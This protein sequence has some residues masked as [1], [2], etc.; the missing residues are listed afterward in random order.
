MQHGQM[1][2]SSAQDG[3]TVQ[4]TQREVRMSRSLPQLRPNTETAQARQHADRPQRPQSQGATGSTRRPYAQLLPRSP[5]P[6]RHG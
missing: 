2:T 3:H 5:V 1:I 6:D 4:R